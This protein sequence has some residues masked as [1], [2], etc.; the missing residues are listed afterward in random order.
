MHEDTLAKRKLDHAAATIQ[1]EEAAAKYGEGD[2]RVAKKRKVVVTAEKRVEKVKGDLE[3]SLT[4]SSQLK[5]VGS[6]RVL[7]LL[8]SINESEGIEKKEYVLPPPSPHTFLSSS[9]D[10]DDVPR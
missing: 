1:L 5:G 2:E 7:S 8:A 3:K 9:N 6:G 4:K 10:V